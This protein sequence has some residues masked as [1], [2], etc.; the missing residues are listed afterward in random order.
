MS[1]D[2]EQGASE[3][4]V[5]VIESAEA[6]APAI[7]ARLAA[8]AGGISPRVLLLGP[9]AAAFP[10]VACGCQLVGH[11]QAP[12][13]DPRLALRALRR[14]L[15]GVGRGPRVC[16]G[17]SIAAASLARVGRLDC[18]CAIGAVE[19]LTSAERAALASTTIEV[20]SDAQAA[21]CLACVGRDGGRPETRI[22]RRRAPSGDA[23]F[24]RVTPCGAGGTGRRHLRAALG[25]DD[26]TVLVGV[27][28]P[29]VAWT[30][31]RRAVDIVGIAAVRG[32]RVRLV[33][34]PAMA[35]ASETARWIAEVG[36][37]E[38]P[39]VLDPIGHDPLALTEAIDMGLVLGDGFATAGAAARGDRG[40]GIGAILAASSLR[41]VRVARH[42]GL[43]WQ[44]GWWAAA[45]VPLLV[46][47]GSFIN[48]AEESGSC[49]WTRTF[50]GD[51]P[52]RATR[53]LLESLDAG[54]LS[55]D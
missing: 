36:L 51:D 35:R 20:T 53:L 18:W 1:T 40:R 24:E 28:G 31:L 47:E 46:E 17:S 9:S 15:A 19:P 4:A 26:A 14:E 52:L 27:V 49:A 3:A 55:R 50:R 21:D 43:T 34:S 6:D 22:A 45:G 44:A 39:L 54:V 23:P 41:T 16:W 25:V 13:G 2:P 30:D 7:A 12:L 29:L 8:V 48:E 32:A 38:S 11:V 5:H 42:R 10:F 37:P 33:G